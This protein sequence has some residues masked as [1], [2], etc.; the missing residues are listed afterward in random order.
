MN[1]WRDALNDGVVI[2]ACPLALD[3]NGEWSKKHQA[4]LLRYYRESGAGGVAVGVHT[5]QFEIRSPKIGLYEAVLRL[6][7][8][9]LDSIA[10]PSFVRVAGICG[11]TKQAISE[12]ELAGSLNYH[13]GLLNIAALKNESDTVRLEHCRRVAD[14]LPVFGFFLQPAVGGCVLSYN[15]WRQFCEIN[16]VVAIKIAAFNRYQTWDVIRAVI[17]SGRNDI[18]LYTGND[19][20]IIN[21]LLTPFRHNNTTRFFAGGL[22][23]QWA[24]W[25]KRAVSMLAEIKEARRNAELPIEWLTRNAELTD[26]NAAIFDAANDFRGCVPGINELL[27]RQR[28]L[29][30]ARCLNINEVLS[31]G[32][33]AELDRVCAAYPHLTDGSFVLSRV[34]EWLR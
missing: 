27:R 19:D 20:N 11:S 25:T 1:N 23:G 21:D 32:Q 33:S 24:V 12:A 6:T 26:A 18:A 34:D 30:S 10:S 17:D 29:P 16:N 9:T 22:L 8:D 13:C 5:T 28:L 14:A 2:P 31:P 7:S 4:A 3:D 15:F